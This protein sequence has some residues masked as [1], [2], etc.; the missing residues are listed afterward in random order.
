[1]PRGPGGSREYL[2]KGPAPGSG[3]CFNCGLEGHWARDC[4]AGDWKNKCYRCGERGHI[5]KKC[6]NS[7]KKLR[8]LVLELLGSIASLFSTPQY[9]FLSV[10]DFVMFIAV[11]GIG[12]THG[13]L[14]GQGHVHVL[15]VVE[16]TAEAAAIG[17][18]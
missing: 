4:K 8:Y 14:S 18:F 10:I 7:P 13:H 16:V 12:A 5:E 6:P 1:M 11:D 17:E 15:L 2:G 3:R 9:F